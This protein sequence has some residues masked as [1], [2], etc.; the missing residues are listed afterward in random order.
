MTPTMQTKGRKNGNK[1][2]VTEKPK[3][4]LA[5]THIGRRSFVTHFYG[6]MKTSEIMRQTGHKT[7]KVFFEY[8]NEARDFD[9][10]AVRKSKTNASQIKILK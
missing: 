7:E 6:K 2:M 1:S 5:S 8:L 10:E 4:Q 3:Y 9:V